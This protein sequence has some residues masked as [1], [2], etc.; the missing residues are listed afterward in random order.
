[1]VAELINLPPPDPDAPGPFRYAETENLLTL[2]DRAGFGN[3]DVSDWRG[4]LPIG[5]GLPTAEA[6]NFALASVASFSDLLAEAGNG[7]LNEARRAL[8]VRL[9]EHQQDGS[10]RMDACV[11]IFTDTRPW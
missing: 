6:A 1:V 11:H 8:T 2:L 10:V 3:L 4:V 5:G 7:V 9:S